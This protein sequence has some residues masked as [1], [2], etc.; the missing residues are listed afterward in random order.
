MEQNLRSY[1]FLRDVDA[2]AKTVTA[3]ISTGD[4]A[5]DDA[6]IDPEGWDFSHYDKNP[7]VLDGHNDLSALGIVAR[8]RDRKVQD[9]KLIA[10]AE[11]DQAD[12]NAMRVFGK[13]ERGFLR[14]TSVRWHPRT[15]EWRDV[16]GRGRHEEQKVLVFTNQELLEWSFVPVPTDPGALILRADGE[17]LP[18]SAFGPKAERDIVAEFLDHTQAITAILCEAGEIDTR[19]LDGEA[20][21]TV[22]TARDALVTLLNSRPAEVPE[23][24]PPEELAEVTRV[25]EDLLLTRDQR[26]LRLIDAVDANTERTA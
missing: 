19:R 10:T 7:V 6:I 13:I 15:W 20:V 9:G 22:R 4:V 24:L 25:I 18:F 12:E 14:A 16:E 5:R 2:E 23:R 1:G 26:T 8:T 11:F 3:V 21:V 17:A